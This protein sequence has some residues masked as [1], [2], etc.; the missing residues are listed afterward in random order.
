MPV[1]KRKANRKAKTTSEQSWAQALKAQGIGVD[2]ENEQCSVST[3]IHPADQHFAGGPGG[4]TMGV[5]PVSTKPQHK[6]KCIR[7]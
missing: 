7:R 6:S 2:R 1:T 5:Y 4:Y 3:D